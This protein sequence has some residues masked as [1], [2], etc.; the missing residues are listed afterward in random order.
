MW[1]AGV[2]DLLHRKRP[3][4]M[5]MGT[6]QVGSAVGRLPFGRA[7]QGS[8]GPPSI[9][10]TCSSL[11]LRTEVCG[12]MSFMRPQEYS[13]NEV[14][15]H[16]EQDLQ[17]IFAISSKSG[18]PTNKLLSFLAFIETVVRMF[19]HLNQ[20]TTSGHC[21]NPDFK[22]WPMKNTLPQSSTLLNWCVVHK[23][24]H[25]GSYPNLWKKKDR[26][27][28]SHCIPTKIKGFTL[29]FWIQIRVALQLTTTP[30]L[31]SL[32]MSIPRPVFEHILQHAPVQRVLHT[33]YIWNWTPKTYT[34]PANCISEIPANLYQHT[35][36]CNSC[37]HKTS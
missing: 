34:N 32:S 31:W 27:H 5:L 7:D 25:A 18:M 21:S 3:W 14:I 13:C 23:S 28:R 36:V 37:C 16:L 2:Q 20:M 33:F 15:K 26:K 12:Y 1:R 35:E 9:L 22:V 19:E 24:L 4:L 10:N 6:T 30:D 8:F 11:K 29:V 17:P